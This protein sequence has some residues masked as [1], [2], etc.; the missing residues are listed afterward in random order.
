MVSTYVFM[1]IWFWAMFKLPY[2]FFR[3]L[4]FQANIELQLESTL[5]TNGFQT[6]V[7]PF[8]PLTRDHITKCLISEMIAQGGG[9]PSRQDTRL[10]LDEMEFFS[11]TFPIFSASGCKRIAGKVKFGRT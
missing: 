10:I 3:N 6:T 5:R 1:K 9:I 8:L 4:L 11:D 2:S 7:V